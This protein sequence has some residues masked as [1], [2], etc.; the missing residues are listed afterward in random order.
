MPSSLQKTDTNIPTVAY[1][2]LTLLVDWWI[3]RFA[4]KFLFVVRVERVFSSLKSCLI[5]MFS[6]YE[7]C[8]GEH[9]C[10]R[11][12]M[13]AGHCSAW[14]TSERHARSLEMRLE[15]IDRCGYTT[16][17]YYGSAGEVS[18]TCDENEF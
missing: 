1:L 15:E 5:H 13:R 11:I 6:Q 14:A 12:F 4:V 17:Y 16:V 10:A 3:S 2:G 9:I 18:L 7:M 8:V